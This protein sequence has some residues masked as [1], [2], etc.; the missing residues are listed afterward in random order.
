MLLSGRPFLM[1]SRKDGSQQYL[2]KFSMAQRK[3]IKDL[4]W[5]AFDAVNARPGNVKESR[6]SL[7]KAL[8]AVE[9]L[10]L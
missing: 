8:K 7:A 9:D 10:P 6:H 3:A 2:D 1:I 4:V 5:A